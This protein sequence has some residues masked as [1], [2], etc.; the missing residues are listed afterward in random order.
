MKNKFLYL[1]K[2]TSFKKGINIPQKRENG[3]NGL[4]RALNVK[5]TK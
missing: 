5:L 3:L 1:V 2:R 4:K